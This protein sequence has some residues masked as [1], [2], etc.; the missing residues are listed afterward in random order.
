[1]SPP[2]LYEYADYSTGTISATALR[3][4]GFK[5][6]VR[7]I[8]SPELMNPPG[9]LQKHM[10]RAEYQD[11]ISH[12]L[13]VVFVHQ[14]STT[15]SDTGF[16]GGVTSGQR[17]L[18][19]L[20]YLGAPLS[21]PVFLTN[22]RPT[23]PSAASWQEYLRGGR[24]VLGHVGQYGFR[25]AIDAGWGIADYSWQCGAESTLR[26]GVHMYQWNNGTRT[27]AGR[28]CDINR[29]FIPLLAGDTMSAEDAYNG[30]AQMIKDMGNGAATDLVA[31]LKWSLGLSDLQ[32]D[33]AVIKQ[34]LTSVQASQGGVNQATLDAVKAELAPLFDLAERL[35]D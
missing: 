33:V 11:H 7:Y 4:A 35:K 2:V 14:G 34:G 12:G 30:V 13:D 26:P 28:V 15:D 17:A 1:V 9:F 23:L 5:G 8:T 3:A 31:A 27:V 6:S 16:S 21:T 25:N 20:R 24:S 19:G 22:D 29:V 10:T 18:A 32:K